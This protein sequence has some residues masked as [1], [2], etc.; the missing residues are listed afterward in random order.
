M[1]GVTATAKPLMPKWITDLFK[2][3]A[4]LKPENDE[5]SKN[6]TVT[7]TSDELA[8]L[9]AAANGAQLQ[10]GNLVDVKSDDFVIVEKNEKSKPVQ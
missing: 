6:R 10:P 7:L 9:E 2:K 1:G 8:D 5:D 4:S 3:V